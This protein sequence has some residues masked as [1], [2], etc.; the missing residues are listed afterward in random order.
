LKFQRELENLVVGRTAQMRT[1]VAR[2]ERVV[3]A[4]R[5][6]DDV[7]REHPVVAYDAAIAKVRAALSHEQD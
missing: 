7:Y 5:A 1:L 3:E 2:A 4:L 6:V